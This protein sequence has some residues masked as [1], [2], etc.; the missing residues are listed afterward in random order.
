MYAWMQSEKNS[1][2]S[3][4]LYFAKISDMHVC[5]GMHQQGY[6]LLLYSLHVMECNLVISPNTL[7]D[8]LTQRT[9]LE[10]L[11]S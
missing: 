5:G 10:V 3:D 4:L 8:K 9:T 11:C 2:S 6:F 1:A 7:L